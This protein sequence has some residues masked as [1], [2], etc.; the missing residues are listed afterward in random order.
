MYRILLIED[1]EFILKELQ[2]LLENHGYTCVVWNMKENIVEVM[3]REEPHLVLLDV[4][5]PSV[6]GFTLCTQIRAV[7]TTPIIF[8]TSRNSDA[9]ELVSMTLGGD[10]FITKP[11]NTSILLAR[12]QALLKRSYEHGEQL[13]AHREV[14]LDVAQS[15]LVYKNKSCELTKNEVRILYYLFQHKEMIVPRDD[16]IE[17]LW[18]NRLFID[19]NALSVNITR[20]RNKLK[21]IG[22]QNFIVTR[23]RQGYQI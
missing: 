14:V 19:D 1:D 13:M 22:V 6:D 16:L 23:H 4:N 11:Y 2:L 9:D 3:Q 12:M 21:E 8:V 10:D 7:L 18:D 20:I 5:L 15:R 17:Y